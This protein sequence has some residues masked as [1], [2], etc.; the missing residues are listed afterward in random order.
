MENFTEITTSSL[1]Q[2]T[3]VL[4]IINASPRHMNNMKVL[5]SP[6]IEPLHLK[7]TSSENDNSNSYLTHKSTDSDEHKSDSGHPAISQ[8]NLEVQNSKVQE[9]Q[10]NPFK[11]AKKD[12]DISPVNNFLPLSPDAQHNLVQKSTP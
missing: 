7:N 9:F 12:E 4:T 2:E 3:G 8:E 1:D 10:D 6:K 5:A 11:Q